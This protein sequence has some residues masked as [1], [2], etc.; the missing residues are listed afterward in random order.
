M[1]PMP[2]A[3]G[4]NLTVLVKCGSKE[5]SNG[6]APTQEPGLLAQTRTWEPRQNIYGFASVVRHRVRVVPM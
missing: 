4:M 2:R 6:S 5:L 1:Q 3:R